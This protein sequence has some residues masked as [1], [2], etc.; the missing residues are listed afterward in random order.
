MEILLLLIYEFYIK[1]L[2]YVLKSLFF[3]EN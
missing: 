1:K 2:N 3:M